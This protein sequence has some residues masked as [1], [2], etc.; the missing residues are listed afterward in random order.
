MMV[1]LQKK[2]HRLCVPICVLTC[3]P[4]CVLTC[5]LFAI[6]LLRRRNSLTRTSGSDII[7]TDYFQYPLYRKIDLTMRRC[8]SFVGLGNRLILYYRSRAIL[9]VELVQ[10][11]RNCSTPFPI[12]APQ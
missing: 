8:R 7:K 1:I 3:V 11:L 2:F 9:S 4:I 12:N 6:F 5:V 10:V